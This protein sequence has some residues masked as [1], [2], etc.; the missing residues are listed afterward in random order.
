M[1]VQA[2]GRGQVP[3][4]V[5]AQVQ[6]VEVA[7]GHLRSFVPGVVGGGPVP[8]PVHG[9]ALVA[10]QLRDVGQAVGQVAHGREQ[11]L[12]HVDGQVPA[13]SAGQG[14]EVVGPRRLMTGARAVSLQERPAAPHLFQHAPDPQPQ[15][16]LITVLRAPAQVRR[17]RDQ[18]VQGL[19]KDVAHAGVIMTRRHQARIFPR[20]ALCQACF[21]SK[22][23]S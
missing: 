12:A 1:L 5:A 17:A 21:P 10:R 15:P 4:L 16:V 9:E 3:E 14:P 6:A 18:A 20:K 7:D 13:A 19:I 8:M 23:D 2:F 11:P 22:V